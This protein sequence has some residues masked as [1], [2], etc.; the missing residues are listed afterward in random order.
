MK[1]FSLFAS[2][3]VAVL[4]SQPLLAGV[5]PG[6]YAARGAPNGEVRQLLKYNNRIYAF[7]AFTAIGGVS[8][9]GVAYWNGSMWTAVTGGPDGDISSAAVG[10]DGI[11]VGGNF[12]T[13]S[14]NLALL[15]ASGWL[16]AASE[17]LTNEST[18][19]VAANGTRVIAGGFYW[20]GIGSLAASID[21]SLAVSQRTYAGLP[22]FNPQ[23]YIEKLEANSSGVLGLSIVSGAGEIRWVPAF[24]G[25]GQV[26]TTTF[27]AS[28]I[29]LGP[30][31]IYAAGSFNAINSIA[32]N[33]I[34]RYSAGNWSAMGAGVG[35][36]IRR[37]HQGSDGVL[38][39]SGEQLISGAQN[40]NN[41][42]VWNGTSFDSLGTPA[43]NMGSVNAVLVDGQTIYLGGNFSQIGG[44]SASNLV[45]FTRGQ[46]DGIFS[47]GF[48]N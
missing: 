38:Y 5:Q 36:T 43:A 15:T 33:Q 2:C 20:G 3:I 13:P 19:S 10:S 35:G 31:D 26:L 32:S 7:G 6:S 41:V 40:V 12:T 1:N 39:A 27:G 44:L 14:Q 23:S 16:S 9:P 47:N 18:T 11:Y 22:A 45:V 29:A 21:T 28:H 48:E 8:A 17:P 24:S 46:N 34:A 42:A 30:A 4:G 25:N 37:L